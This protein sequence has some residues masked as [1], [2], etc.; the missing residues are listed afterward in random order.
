MY[1]IYGWLWRKHKICEKQHVLGFIYI[2]QKIQIS[3]KYNKN[4]PQEN[5]VLIFQFS[6]SFISFENIWVRRIVTFFIPFSF[7]HR[8]DNKEKYFSRPWVII[9]SRKIKLCNLISNP[10]MQYNLKYMYST[11]LLILSPSDIN[12]WW[13]PTHAFSASFELHIFHNW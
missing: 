6:P 11:Y 8:Q 9:T 12:D 13:T 10:S 3:A 2:L 4:W 1:T 7:H 5:S